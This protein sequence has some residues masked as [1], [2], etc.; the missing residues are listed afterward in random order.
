MQLGV[1]GGVKGHL[2]QRDKDILQHLA[3]VLQKVLRAVDV[4][5][6]VTRTK[7]MFYWQHVHTHTYMYCSILFS[8]YTYI[9]GRIEGAG[10]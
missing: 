2:K 7:S 5:V 10:L 9:Q 3:K 6:R 8:S 1:S 4:T